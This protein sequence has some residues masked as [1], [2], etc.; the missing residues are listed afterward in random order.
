MR[1]NEWVSL[2]IAVVIGVLWIFLGQPF[3]FEKAIPTLLVGPG[4]ILQVFLQRGTT[5]A[6]TVFWSGCISAL[7]VWYFITFTARTSSSSQVRKMRGMWWLA[8]LA[9]V[10][11]GW[12]CQL[13]FF[14][15]QW[16]LQGQSMFLIP[17]VGWI[18]MLLIVVVDVALLFWLPTVLASPRSF[19][20]VVPGGVSI[21][22]G[23]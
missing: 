3:I 6:F 1:N 7:L 9:L 2:L 5:P 4:M 11:F 19:R 12:L 23:R 8:A 10:I 14:I 17:I 13:F 16:I 22:G 18:M 15:F 21:K 20:L